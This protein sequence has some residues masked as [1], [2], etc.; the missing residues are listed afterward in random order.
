ML[1]LC[2]RGEPTFSTNANGMA[3]ATAFALGWSSPVLRRGMSARDVAR[4]GEGTALRVITAL[5]ECFSAFPP[6][7]MWICAVPTG[8][9]RT[10]AE[11]RAAKEDLELALPELQFVGYSLKALLSSRSA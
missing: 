11:V 8:I 7:E 2:K 1:Y 4:M 5:A 10:F 3:E 9:S 6:R